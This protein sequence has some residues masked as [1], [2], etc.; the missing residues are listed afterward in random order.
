MH[1]FWVP[2]RSFSRKCFLWVPQH[3]AFDIFLFLHENVCC[4]YSL[5]APQWGASN[6]YPQHMV[7]WK[8]KNYINTLLKKKSSR[9]ITK[10]FNFT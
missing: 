1:M 2:I 9:V 5:E 3:M 4:V 7:L 8:N 6:E 10:D